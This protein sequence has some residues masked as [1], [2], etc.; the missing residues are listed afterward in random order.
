M[1]GVEIPHE[2]HLVGHS[3]ADAVLHAVTD[4][5]LGAAALGDIGQMFPDNQPANRGRD[6]SEMLALAYEE[7]AAA[8]YRVVNIDL[9]VHA[10]RPKLAPYRDAMRASIARLLGVDMAAVGVKAKTGEGVGP[11][12]REEVIDVRAV[13]LLQP[14]TEGQP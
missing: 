11:V 1:G 2:K 5:V 9:V 13:A 10:Q 7:V 6:S 14:S 4:A 12:G 3:D 8:G